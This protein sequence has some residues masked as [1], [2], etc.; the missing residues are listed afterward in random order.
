MESKS[1]P[2]SLPEANERESGEVQN[3]LLHRLR[4]RVG[5]VLE[6]VVC[7]AILALAAIMVTLYVEWRDKKRLGDLAQ[8]ELVRRLDHFA[9]SGNGLEFGKERLTALLDIGFEYRQ[10][11]GCHSFPQLV[12]ALR[13]DTERLNQREATHLFSLYGLAK[14]AD[15][16]TRDVEPAPKIREGL[17]RAFAEQ[18]ATGVSDGA[19]FVDW[20]RHATDFQE[21]AFRPLTG[22]WYPR[23]DCNIQ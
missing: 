3:S 20:S 12:S 15:S 21:E 16:R 4:P 18:F 2:T 23:D 6:N 7:A 8:A 17:R 13:D 14:G 10:D 9:F 22:Q 11:F 5:T 19:G 1:T